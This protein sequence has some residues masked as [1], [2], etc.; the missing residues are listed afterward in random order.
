MSKLD[1]V[2]LKKLIQ[3]IYTVHYFQL[4][5][6]CSAQN[7]ETNQIQILT[8]INPSFTILGFR[9]FPPV[10]LIAFMNMF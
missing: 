7:Y 3:F 4:I 6:Q 9:V 8:V 1:F 10:L 2:W 5:H